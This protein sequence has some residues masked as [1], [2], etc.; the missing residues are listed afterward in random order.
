MESQAPKH[1]PNGRP[2]A[3]AILQLAQKTNEVLS[4]NP[5]SMHYVPLPI[6]QL[7]DRVKGIEAGLAIVRDSV[8][9]IS[10]SIE[11]ERK[12][13]FKTVYESQSDSSGGDDDRRRRKKRLRRE[14]S[15]ED[16]TKEHKKRKRKKRRRRLSPSSSDEEDN[17]KREKKDKNRKAGERASI[18]AIDPSV[19]GYALSYIPL[20]EVLEKKLYLT[21]KLFM[22]AFY[23]YDFWRASLR[24]M[25]W[26]SDPKQSPW[27]EFTDGNTDG[28]YAINNGKRCKEYRT[29]YAWPSSVLKYKSALEM[30]DRNSLP[31]LNPENLHIKSWNMIPC[32][33]ADPEIG[34][35][36]ALAPRSRY[37]KKVFVGSSRQ[38]GA[39]SITVLYI[40]IHRLRSHSN[41]IEA[42]IVFADK[43]YEAAATK[44]I[45]RND[46]FQ[47]IMRLLQ[48][49]QSHEVFNPPYWN[50][51][52]D[53]A[54]RISKMQKSL[55]ECEKKNRGIST[56]RG[57]VIRVRSTYFPYDGC[58]A[59]EPSANEK[60]FII[61]TPTTFEK[62]N[63]LIGAEKVK[64]M[65]DAFFRNGNLWS[66]PDEWH[67][68]ATRF[69]MAYKCHLDIKT[70]RDPGA[71]MNCI[72]HPRKNQMS[73]IPFTSEELSID[74]QIVYGICSRHL[75]AK[76]ARQ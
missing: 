31:I 1:L 27:M 41:R 4:I 72:L 73:P 51:M 6:D 11:E 24:S 25:F 21:C 8:L 76:E 23:S 18:S 61:I 58:P 3:E 64:E 22:R 19:L 46:V 68:P 65:T 59:I 42:K 45:H 71:L 10:E 36:D 5:S 32:V 2:S 35:Q 29:G 38:D 34:M 17:P 9:K 16:E 74:L 57:S 26:T 52:K 44:K 14:L 39:A 70:L 55:S 20:R 13:R 48:T 50:H 7:S 15:P 56:P 40:V 69:I 75:R 60:G 30:Y 28:I 33:V 53:D 37:S 43:K 47:G 54:M 49:S 62:L 63:P 67:L 66:R 12:R